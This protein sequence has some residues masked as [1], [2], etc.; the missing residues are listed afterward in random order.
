MRGSMLGDARAAGAGELPS[1]ATVGTTATSSPTVDVH[2]DHVGVAAAD[3]VMRRRRR[4][5]TRCKQFAGARTL[6][7]ADDRKT[8]DV[9]QRNRPGPGERMAFRRDETAVQGAERHRKSEASSVARSVLCRYRPRR[10]RRD[11]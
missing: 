10:R 7:V 3:H 2:P 11:G 1:T 8:R 9:G 5:E 4:L 6:V